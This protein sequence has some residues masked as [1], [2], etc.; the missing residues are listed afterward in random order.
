M[1]T[2]LHTSSTSP[3][4][5]VVVVS[6]STIVTVILFGYL[7]YQARFL[8]LGP[9]VTLTEAGHSPITTQTV[10][11]KGTAANITHM[12]LNGRA[13]FTDQAGVFQETL[14]L[15]HGYNLI[16]ITARDRYGREHSIIREFV[17]QTDNDQNS[18]NSVTVYDAK[19]LYRN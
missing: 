14:V 19:K 6:C 15:N 2:T 12:T 13:I 17:Q 8:I 9:Q 7:I 18:S 11:L 4:R 10:E 1:H 16:T 3:L 5:R